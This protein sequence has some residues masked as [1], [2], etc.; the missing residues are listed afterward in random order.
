M[1]KVVITLML[2]LAPLFSQSQNFDK[3]ENMKEV[4]AMVMTSKMFKMLAKVDMS[5]SD[6][7]AQQYIKLIENLDEIKMFT[8]SNSEG[9]TS[10]KIEHQNELANDEQ[11]RKMLDAALVTAKNYTKTPVAVTNTNLEAVG[12]YNLEEPID[13]I[14]SVNFIETK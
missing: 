14:A 3:Y 5:D 10:I 11:T 12:P 13:E 6:P 1:N 7:E 4:D 2:A 8:S 9:L